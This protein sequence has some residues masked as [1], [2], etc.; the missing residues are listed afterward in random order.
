MLILAL[1]VGEY[2]LIYKRLALPI[3]YLSRF[4]VIIS[5]LLLEALTRSLAV[6]KNML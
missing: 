5:V 1:V 3:R 4:L 6:N 2:S